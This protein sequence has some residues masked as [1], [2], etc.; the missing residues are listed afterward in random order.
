MHLY[1]TGYRGS[2]KSSVARAVGEALGVDVIDLD[3]V[4]VQSA[5]RS[6][7]EIFAAEGEAGFRD[8][9]AAALAEVAQRAP[10]VVALGGGAILR[11][12]NRER[13]RQ[14]GRCVWLVATAETLAARIAADEQNA[15]APQRPSLTQPGGNPADEVATILRQ[16]QPQYAAAADHQINVDRQSVPEI[17]EQILDWLDTQLS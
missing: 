16:R 8:Q 5:G 1:L 6:I 7:P 13:I 9:E 17:A 3:E 4:I 12:S 15:N 11:E 14:T 2:G 10:S